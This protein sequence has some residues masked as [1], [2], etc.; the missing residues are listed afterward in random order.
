MIMNMYL[1]IIFVILLQHCM[2][3]T[4]NVCKNSDEKP[5]GFIYFNIS[6]VFS[7]YIIYNNYPSNIIQLD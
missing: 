3:Y 2:I 1:F 4:V 7:G 5:V 6:N